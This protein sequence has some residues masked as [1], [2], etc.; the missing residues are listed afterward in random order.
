MR[1]KKVKKMEQNSKRDGVKIDPTAE[2]HP[3]AKIGRGTSIWNICQIRENVSIGVECIIGTGVYIDFGVMIGNRVKIQNGVKIYH[4]V[5][6]DDGVFLGP[7]MCFTNDIY[8]RAI[9]PNGSLKGESDWVVGKT[10]VKKGASIG[11]MSVILPG[12]TIGEFALIGAG[13]VVTKDVPSFALVYG[14]PARIAGYVC[15][16]GKGLKQG[17]RCRNCGVINNFPSFKTHK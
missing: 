10:K 8:P 17:I 2:I 16:C 15:K 11:A 5:E 14:N 12:I 6:V 3:S 13:S 4:G 1:R 7:G 9:N